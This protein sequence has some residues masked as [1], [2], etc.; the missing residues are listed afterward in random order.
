MHMPVSEVAAVGALKVLGGEGRTD[1][2]RS[3]NIII[4]SIAPFFS[5]NVTSI[6]IFITT[7]VSQ[8]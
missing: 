7:F 8:D 1:G 2:A 4:C 5:T 6:F 3:V